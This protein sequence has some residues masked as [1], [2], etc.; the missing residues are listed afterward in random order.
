MNTA[1]SATEQEMIPTVIV[2]ADQNP[3]YDTNPGEDAY[4]RV[5]LLSIDKANTYF[6]SSEE[7][8]CATTAYAIANGAT[9]SS[10]NTVD[11]ADAGWWWL[12]SPGDY[13]YDVAAVNSDGSVRDNGFDVVSGGSCVRPA[14][15]ITV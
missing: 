1:F 10:S 7:R 14:L 15:W 9:T 5:F 4:D 6:S 11:G 3:D 13:S 8:L 12:R 2:T